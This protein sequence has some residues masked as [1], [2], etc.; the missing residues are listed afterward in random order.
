MLNRETEYV[1]V[2]YSTKFDFLRT[3]KNYKI[4][5]GGR[6]AMKS[7]GF[8]QELIIKG[9]ENP[10]RIFCG[11]EVLKSI[12][13][14][15]HSVLSDTIKRCDLEHVYDVQRK[16][17]YH[18]NGTEFIFGGLRYDTIRS[19][20]S[21]EGIDIAWIDEAQ[22]VCEDSWLIFLPTLFRRDGPEL[23]ASFNT[24]LDTD[25]TYQ[26]FVTPYFDSI[27]ERGFYDDD[28]I[29]VEKVNYYDNPWLTDNARDLIAFDKA[30]NFP[31]Y[32]NVWEG[33]PLKITDAQVFKNWRVDPTIEPG[34][35]DAI[36]FGAD[37]GFS[38]HPSTLIGMWINEDKREICIDREAYKV[39]VEI[40]D[41]PDFYDRVPG[42]RQWKIMADDAS[43]NIISYLKRQG[44]NIEGAKK[45]PGSIVEGVKFLQSYDIVIHPRCKHTIAELGFYSYKVRINPITQEK[46]VL[47]ILVDDNNHA[48]D[49][50]R[51]A[52]GR[53]MKKRK[54][55]FGFG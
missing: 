2:E 1:D 37:F 16:A 42:S 33:E 9:H 49:S 38:V 22:D 17:I 30:R 54:P 20:K 6:N 51:Y 26:R 48:I 14:S 19:V 24:V 46:E 40:D 50:L 21:M 3:P 11:R 53:F 15:V 31:L 35:D 25:A 45:P 13:A 8:A 18:K 10:L 52:L 12:D 4:A 44:F 27:K 28:K 43:P 41:M 5:F 7:W 23:W 36:Y 39:G 55:N 47:A 34:K 32:L 29:H